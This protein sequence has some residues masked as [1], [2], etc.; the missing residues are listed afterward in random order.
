ME[1]IKGPKTLLEAIRYFSDPDVCLAFMVAIRFP[2]GVTC[3][4]CGA[5]DPAFLAKQRLWQ[6]KNKHAHRQFSIKKNSIFEESPL[7]LQK[8]LPAVWLIMSCKNGISS[9]ELHRALKVTQ[10]TAWFMLHRIRTAMALG[11]FEKIAGQVEID[12]TFIGGKARFMHK[13]QR[14]KKIKGTGGT[15]S[16][17]AAVMGLLERHGP[18]K[19]H[20]TVRTKV[21]PNT[22]KRTLQDEVRTHVEAGAEVFTDALASYDGLSPEYVHQVI[23]HAECYA[24]GQVHTNGLE[25]FWS[26]TKRMIKGTYVSVEPWHLARY[27]D[28]E[29]FRFNT[30]KDTDAG[31]F[32]EL[33][34][35]VFGR[36]LTYRE[37][38]GADVTEGLFASQAP[39]AREAAPC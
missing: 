39:M 20:S 3:Q 4:I 34:R 16:G 26:L 21:I 28:E 9:M 15:G 6:C 32:V 24:R 36:R 10:K 17:K 18:D 14:A 19:G 29:A 12:E 2:D 35:S 38:I 27:L 1:E 23:D 37:L 11:S 30:S 5:K 7:P 31:R 22:R 25:N 8:W 33:L 13:D